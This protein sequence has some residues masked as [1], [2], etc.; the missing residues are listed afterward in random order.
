VTPIAITSAKKPAGEESALADEQQ[1]SPAGWLGLRWGPLAF[2]P[3]G[4]LGGDCLHG[5]LRAGWITSSRAGDP[6]NN[7]AR[8]SLSYRR[9]GIR[10]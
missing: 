5:I 1:P 2:F 8:W 3:R 9:A 4:S 10:G 6:A 7:Q